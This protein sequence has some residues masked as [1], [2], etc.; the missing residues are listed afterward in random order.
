MASIEKTQSP[1]SEAQEETIA[2]GGAFLAF[3]E[4]KRAG[5]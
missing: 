3:A 5:I 2:T 4:L 1:L